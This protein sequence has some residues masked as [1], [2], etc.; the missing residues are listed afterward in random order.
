MTFDSKKAVEA[1]KKAKPLTL[2]DT[3]V[4]DFL[5]KLPSDPKSK[6]YL[7]D[8]RNE[9]PKLLAFLNNAKIKAEKKASACLKQIHDDIDKHLDDVK[10]NRKHVLGDMER[11]RG[12]AK[13][14]FAEAIKKPTEQ[15]LGDQWIKVMLADRGSRVD[16]RSPA[17]HEFDPPLKALIHDWLAA[18]ATLD[19][20]HTAL[21]GLLQFQ[22]QKVKAGTPMPNF[23]PELLKRVKQFGDA[24]GNLDKVKQAVNG[25]QL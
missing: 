16:A 24:V 15:G 18:T 4:S 22:A 5:R 12:A 21:L 14:Y 20:A 25:I 23:Q 2:T 17:A 3:G 6:T 11:I 7:A 8:L 10:A 1:W 9:K 19:T 13:D